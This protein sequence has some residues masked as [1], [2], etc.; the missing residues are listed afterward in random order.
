MT[1]TVASCT[2]SSIG[3][4]TRQRRRARQ[5]AVTRLPVVDDGKIV[6]DFEDGRLVG[7]VTRAD[8]V[9]AF[10]RSDAD[11]RHDINEVIERYWETR[12]GEV[13]VAVSQGEVILKGQVELRETAEGL[14]SA[15]AHVPGIVCVE[16]E[17]T[18]CMEIADV[19]LDTYQP[20]TTHWPR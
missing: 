13:D 17:L 10:A 3:V 19:P 15:I 18:W 12:P 4:M 5:S 14:S 20:V 7:I 9:R 16:S 1:R 8:F 2:G 11:L 6:G